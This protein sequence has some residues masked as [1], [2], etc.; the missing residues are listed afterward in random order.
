[1]SASHPEPSQ[2]VDLHSQHSADD[3]ADT[4]MRSSVFSRISD[5]GS[6]SQRKRGRTP[7]QERDHETTGEWTM[8]RELLPP[9]RVGANS[10]A[11]SATRTP[12]PAHSGSAPPSPVQERARS[13]YARSREFSPARSPRTVAPSATRAPLSEEPEHFS[14]AEPSHAPL[15][16]ANTP[17]EY[18]SDSDSD[19]NNESMLDTS[20]PAATTPERAPWL[21]TKQKNIL[22][23]AIAYFIGSLFTFS[24][25]LS[26]LISD[27]VPLRQDEG[28]SPS[29]HMVATS[30]LD[31][32]LGLL[33]AYSQ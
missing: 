31:A 26:D 25:Y 14:S 15:H 12:L 8:F 13:L 30:Q 16:A 3:D 7:R 28:P 2:A 17:D 6:I 29:G 33:I 5:L 4:G 19:E 9:T 27:I 18:D 22:K 20:A 24:P 21:S 32:Y 1:M 11:R 10:R 23:C